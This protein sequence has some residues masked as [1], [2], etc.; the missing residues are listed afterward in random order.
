MSHS[1]RFFLWVYLKIIKRL[2]RYVLARLGQVFQPLGQIRPDINPY[3]FAVLPV[4]SHPPEISIHLSA[5]PGDCLLFHVNNFHPGKFLIFRHQAPPFLRFPAICALIALSVKY[6][7]H[8]FPRGQSLLLL[9][10]E[11]TVCRSLSTPSL[12]PSSRRSFTAIGKETYLRDQERGI[13]S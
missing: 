10:R 9:C 5:R 1:P 4:V 6:F 7:F 12:I 2:L 8:P 13:F 3:S 11:K